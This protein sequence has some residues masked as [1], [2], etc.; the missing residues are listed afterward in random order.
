[1]DLSSRPAWSTERVP[2]Q[3][4]LHR[5]TFSTK[6]K[7][8]KQENPLPPSPHTQKNKNPAMNPN[9]ALEL[10]DHCQIP[11]P[12]AWAVR[13]W[14]GVV[15]C[16]RACSILALARACVLPAATNTDV[17]DYPQGLP[18]SGLAMIYNSFSLN[19]P[20]TGK[21]NLP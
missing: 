6:Q 8:N 12:S 18:C 3:P 20:N 17:T 2:G 1:V 21:N 15:F 5:E 13:R 16:D 19:A 9:V 10:F 4:G 11:S 14:V 7:L